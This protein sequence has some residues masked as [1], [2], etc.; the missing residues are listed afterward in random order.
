MYTH[1]FIHFKYPVFVIFCDT[2][3]ENKLS[4]SSLAT[5]WATT[6]YHHIFSKGIMHAILFCTTLVFILFDVV[7]FCAG[8][9]LSQA[10]QDELARYISAIRECAS[11]P[12]ELHT[13]SS[14]LMKWI[15]PF[16]FLYCWFIMTIGLYKHFVHNA[17]YFKAQHIVSCPHS[18][19]I[20]VLLYLHLYI[21]LAWLVGC[22]EDLRRFSGISAISRLGSR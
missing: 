12:G 18:Q 4:G 1:Y 22:I 9:V 5:Y 15:S 21:K 3:G 20:I 19:P 2:Y 11:V 6:L 17:D 7:Y 14:F 13:Y 16:P 10:D 8:E